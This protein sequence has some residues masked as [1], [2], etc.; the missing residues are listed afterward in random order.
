MRLGL[1]LGISQL[2]AATGGPI[3][4]PASLFA[5]SEQG[6]WLDPSDL[7]TMFQ[8]TAGTTPVTA[9]GQAVARIND[10]SGNG[11][12]ATQATLANRPILRLDDGGR[13][14]LECDGTNDFLVTPTITPG[15]DI[16]QVFSGIRKLSDTGIQLVVESGSASD[17]SDNGAFYIAAPRNSGVANYGFNSGGTERR[18][19]IAAGYTA[20]TTNVVG[21]LANISSDIGTLRV[22][23][24]QVAI[25]TQDRGTGNFL[26]YQMYIASR[27]G[28]S[29]F[30]NGRIYG[31]FVRFGPLLN[32]EQIAGMESYMATKA[33]VTL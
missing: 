22:D 3:F 10:K 23:G 28:S 16:V 9:A 15:T 24:A 8:D 4:N 18:D 1:S 14:Y 5:A 27:A 7:S 6:I 26:P 11:Y 32:S 21:G 19:A 12:N 31:L 20:P 30:F 13:Y 2:P 29:L 33:G 25:N 17:G